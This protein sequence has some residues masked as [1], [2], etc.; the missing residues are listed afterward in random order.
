MSLIDIDA[1]LQERL[2]E[3]KTNNAFRSLPN[4]SDGIDFCSNDYLGMARRQFSQPISAQYGATGS[5]LIS[6][7]HS[8]YS[9]LEG[10]LAYFHR[11]ESAL[12]YNSGYQANLGLISCMATRHDTIL[13]DQLAHASIRDAVRLSEARSLSFRHNDVHHLEEKLERANGRKFVVVESVYSMD[14]DE[15]PL[16]ELAD[17]CKAYDAALIVD[18]AHAV[19]VLGPQGRGLVVE[20]GLEDQVWARVVTFGKALGSHGAAILGSELLRDYLINFSRPFIY[21]TG[22]PP[23]TVQRILQAYRYLEN[24]NLPEQILQ[25]TDRFKN[26]IAGDLRASLIASRSAI[27]SLVVPGNAAVK[28]AA[29]ALQHAGFRILPILSPTV[30]KGSERLRICLHTFNTE[31]QIDQLVLQLQKINSALLKK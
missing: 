19:G 28:E 7:N 11:S 16:P 6:G 15:A 1:Y 8:A 20:M 14:G 3:R 26:G 10:F 30:P 25:K 21:T 23:D 9:E 31:E 5:R 4:L 12:V 22:L 24:S 18:E 13:Y 2:Q 27:Q 17:C 29:L